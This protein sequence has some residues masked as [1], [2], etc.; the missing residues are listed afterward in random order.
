MVFIPPPGFPF[1][2]GIFD[3][4][5]PFFPLNPGNGAGNGFPRED[6]EEHL[7]LSQLRAVTRE[8]GR[9]FLDIFPSSNPLRP[10]RKIPISAPS[11]HKSQDKGWSQPR[12]RGAAG[13]FP[14]RYRIPHGKK[15]PELTGINSLN[16]DKFF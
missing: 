5:N 7:E 4:W 6:E 11:D 14:L 3:L 2:P 12:P 9:D 1:I 15:P 10:L 13:S 16:W 8:L